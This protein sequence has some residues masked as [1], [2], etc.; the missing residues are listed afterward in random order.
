VTSS[1]RTTIAAGF[2]GMPFAEWAA[3]IMRKIDGVFSG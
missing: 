3:P 1:P 2:C